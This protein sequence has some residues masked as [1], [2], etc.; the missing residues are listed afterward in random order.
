MLL[1]FATLLWLVPL[2]G[3]KI[4]KMPLPGAF[5]TAEWDKH[6]VWFGLLFCIYSMAA[7]IVT[8]A[9]IMNFR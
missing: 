1:I 8:L 9:A 6:P 5:L 3:L 2:C 7:F 4:R